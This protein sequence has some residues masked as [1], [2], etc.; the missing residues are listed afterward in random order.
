MDIMIRHIM[1]H[2][3]AFMNMIAAFFVLLIFLMS[4]CEKT[5]ETTVRS[6]IPDFNSIPSIKKKKEKFFSYMR[7]F[8]V[9]RNTEIRSKRKKLL[10]LYNKYLN[11]ETLT[12]DEK[13]WI[14]ILAREYKLDKKRVEPVTRW[15][16]LQRRVDIVPVDLALMQAAKE[17]GW[18]TSRFARL[19]Y[20]MYGHRCYNKG[21]GIIPEERGAEETYEVKKFKSVRDSV[22]EYMR[23]LNTGYAYHDFRTL[24][25][26]IRENEM[27]PDGYSLVPGLQLYS[28][29]GGA[30][31]EELQE[32]I[33][34]NRKYLD[35]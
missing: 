10:S 1:I 19:G 11:K 28:E 3:R 20:N 31:L 17:S 18:G 33:L 25:F 23:N 32:M 5:V 16:L 24:R 13:S 15:L 6:D 9:E 27:V 2:S 26:T 8:I 14:D 12:M 35:S 34:D 22:R 7:P 29:R 30:Y 21:C 4:G